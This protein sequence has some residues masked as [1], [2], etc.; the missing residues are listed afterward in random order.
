[1]SRNEA[2][3][4]LP[5]CAQSKW[6]YFLDVDG[7][8]IDHTEN[9]DDVRV[10]SELRL[11]LENL[12]ARCQGAVAL[13][14]G[15]K[16]QQLRELFDI[17]GIAL[18]GQ[19]GLEGCESN[20]GMWRQAGFPEEV[21]QR[22]QTR[23]RAIL[24]IYS[25]PL[26]EDKGLM[27]TLHC[28]SMSMP[29]MQGVLLPLIN[30]M[31]DQCNKEAGQVVVGLGK[32]GLD[33][34]P[35]QS[36]KAHSVAWLLSTPQFSGRSPVFIGDDWADESAFAEINRRQGVSIKVGTGTTHAKYALENVSQVLIWLAGVAD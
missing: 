11:M 19:N 3:C 1:M 18:V 8:L 32:R 12:R 10:S 21:H 23:L 25:Q 4:L 17:D 7:T 35:S 33:L 24:K 27:M 9:M 16:L 6:A 13:V 14:S 20:G 22:L 36:G 30:R 5:P 15:R 34:M 26:L 29:Y 2:V 31:V 28:R